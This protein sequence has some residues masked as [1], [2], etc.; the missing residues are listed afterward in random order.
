MSRGPNIAAFCLRTQWLAGDLKMKNYVRTNLTIHTISN[1][2]GGELFR[3][4]PGSV[5]SP[6]KP[7][8][9]PNFFCSCFGKGSGFGLPPILTCN[10]DRGLLPK[11]RDL[12]L[13]FSLWV[14]ALVEYHDIRYT[15]YQD[16]R[17]TLRRTSFRRNFRRAFHPCGRELSSELSAWYYPPGRHVNAKSNTK[18]FATRTISPPLT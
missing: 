17:Y 2:Q 14:T 15:V 7:A 6:L 9:V 13:F 16:I 3:A 5:Q 1:R 11:G 4:A 18:G 8:W 12:L 10:P